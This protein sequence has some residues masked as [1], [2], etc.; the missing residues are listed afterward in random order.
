M[1]SWM[2]S[3]AV[4]AAL[5]GGMF[6]GNAFADPR[7]VLQPNHSNHGAIA[8]SSASKDGT[9]SIAERAQVPTERIHMQTQAQQAAMGGEAG[10]ERTGDSADVQRKSEHK[11]DKK[12]QSIGI[13]L[14]AGDNPAERETGATVAKS[15][16]NK[17]GRANKDGERPHFNAKQAEVLGSTQPSRDDGQGA[18]N[19]A[20]HTGSQNKEVSAKGSGEQLH[21]A[22]QQM[23]EM[24]PEGAGNN[25]KAQSSHSPNFERTEARFGREMPEPRAQVMHR[26]QPNFHLPQAFYH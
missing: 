11:A 6:A 12:Q 15:A 21:L 1:K 3:L 10:S 26:E 4:P 24:K 2:K 20:Q 9:A 23:Q 19:K 25:D 13:H 18:S 14:G 17:M 16:T 8:R 7:D 5:A 22:P